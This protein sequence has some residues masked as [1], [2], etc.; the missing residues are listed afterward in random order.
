MTPARKHI[1]NLLTMLRLVLAAAF[2]VLLAMVDVKPKI[3]LIR[4]EL[5]AAIVIFV[6]A[7]ATD[8]LDG[9][10][11]RRWKVVS[12]FGRVVD[13]FADKIL[14]LGGFIMLAGHNFIPLH[15]AGPVTGVYTWMVVVILS[16]E[17]LV[18]TIRGAYESQGIDF[19]ANIWGKWKMVLQSVTIPVVIGI[20]ALDRFDGTTRDWSLYLRDGLLYLTVI[21]TVLSGLPYITQAMRANR[22]PV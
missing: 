4:A 19:S 6:I 18:T 11:A 8:F 3:G 2:F 10:L 9:Y 13:P 1:P 22:P 14:V 5:I 15:H 21:V 20:V 16:R 7:A 12:R 17:L